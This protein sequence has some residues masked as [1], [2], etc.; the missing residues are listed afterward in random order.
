VELAFAPAERDVYSYEHT[1]KDLAPVGA[2]RG[3]E[4][5]LDRAKGCAPP[6]LRSKEK[7]Q[8]G[9]KHLARWGEMTSNVLLHFQLEFANEKWKISFLLPLVNKSTAKQKQAGMPVLQ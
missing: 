5:S 8:Q 2:K 1:P 7:N 6:E 4:R 3:S 9:Y